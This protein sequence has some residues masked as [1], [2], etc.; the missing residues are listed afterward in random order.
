MSTTTEHVTTEHTTTGA[1]TP[2]PGTAA[3]G[4]AQR[5]LSSRVALLAAG[6]AVLLVLLCFASLA[7]GSQPFAPDT[8]IA[9]LTHPDPNSGTDAIIGAR[10]PRTVA[11]LLVGAALGLSGGVLQGITRN[12]LGDAGLLGINAGAA[13]AVVLAIFTVGVGSLTGYVWFAL[14]GAAIATLV[15]FA[16]AGLG[17]GRATPLK[18]A[19]TGATVNAGLASIISGVLVSSSES[20]DAYRQWQVGLIAGRDWEQVLVVAPFLAVGAVLALVSGPALNGLALGDDVA[21]GLGQ[22]IGLTRAVVCVGVVLLA[23]GATALAGPVAFIGLV[24]PHAV[25]SLTGPDYRAVLPLCA[26]LGPTLLLGADILGRVIAP[27]GEIAVGVMTAVIGA[28]VFIALV[29]RRKLG[30]L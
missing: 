4:G 10:V 25:R 16:L 13:V 12:P 1:T 30:A 2:L 14:A 3:R 6:S 11:G 24:I 19:I 18:L 22:R 7:I 15:I 26:L 17:P 9:A 20:F 8:V 21:R 5:V 29:R 28:P 27:P 23:G